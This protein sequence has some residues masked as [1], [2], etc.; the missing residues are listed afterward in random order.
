VY[1]L[2]MSK[3]FCNESSMMSSSVKEI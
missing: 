1:T 2:R 3:A